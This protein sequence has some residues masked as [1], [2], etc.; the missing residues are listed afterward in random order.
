[1]TLNGLVTCW[2][3]APGPLVISSPV[4]GRGINLLGAYIPRDLS[5]HWQVEPCAVPPPYG[6]VYVSRY[7]CELL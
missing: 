4:A 2:P 7:N 1:M 5:A 3:I 6:H